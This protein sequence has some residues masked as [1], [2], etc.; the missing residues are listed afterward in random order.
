LAVIHFP[1]GDKAAPS[2]DTIA[3]DDKASIDK[4]LELATQRDLAEV[5]IIGRKN[6]GDVW[7]S[8]NEGDI[9]NMLFLLETAKAILIR[10]A[11]GG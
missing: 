11:L 1:N 4:C 8:T 3:E 10:E 7:F 2:S 6:D 9:G 5:F